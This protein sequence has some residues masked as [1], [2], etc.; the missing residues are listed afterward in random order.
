[1]ACLL[2]CTTLNCLIQVQESFYTLDFSSL[3]FMQSYSE[4]SLFTTRAHYFV[5][6]PTSQNLPLNKNNKCTKKLTHSFQS[7]TYT[8][9]LCKGDFLLSF[10]VVHSEV[11][12]EFG[13]QAGE[14]V[15]HG[16]GK[17]AST[18][19]SLCLSFLLHNLPVEDNSIL[20]GLLLQWLEVNLIPHCH[21]FIRSVC[22]CVRAD[23]KRNSLSLRQT[24]CGI[25]YT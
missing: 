11:V 23:L 9:F 8:I 24:N 17:L 21:S 12:V 16:G 14:Y 15:F 3:F 18:T 7:K 5:L 6:G 1:M 4:G 19:F 10:A 25:C 2:I 22:H 13:R 20:A